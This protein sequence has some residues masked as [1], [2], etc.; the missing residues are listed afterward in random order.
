M[1]F[2]ELMFKNDSYELHKQYAYNVRLCPTNLQIYRT[3]KKKLIYNR[4]IGTFKNQE[5]SENSS[6]NTHVNWYKNT[7]N[8]ML[9]KVTLYC[10]VY[11]ISPLTNV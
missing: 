1:H 3:Q 5:Y 6:D 11:S 8:T 4:H 2:G 7:Y 9:I 10:L